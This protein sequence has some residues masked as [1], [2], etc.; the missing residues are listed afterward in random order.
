M[1]FLYV[2]YNGQFSNQKVTHFYLLTQIFGEKKL[3]KKYFCPQHPDTKTL[4]AKV[5]F[6]VPSSRIFCLS[7]HPAFG[8][9][10][11]VSALSKCKFNTESRNNKIINVLYGK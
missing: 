6:R 3:P 11:R 9:L 4:G 10:A 7:L 5:F 8:R 1:L 2:R